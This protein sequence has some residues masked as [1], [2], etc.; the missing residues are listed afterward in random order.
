MRV[1]ILLREYLLLLNAKPFP[2]SELVGCV[3]LLMLY[4]L[5]NG[6]LYNLKVSRSSF[7][8]S[9]DLQVIGLC[10][11]AQEASMRDVNSIK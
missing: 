10:W 1:P 3:Y 11:K 7:H 6:N 4:L 8:L 5:E 2:F 9:D